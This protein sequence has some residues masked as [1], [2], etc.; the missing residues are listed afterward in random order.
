MKIFNTTY[1]I[2]SNINKKIVLISDL[3]Y[4]NKKNIFILN[5][6]FDKIKIINPDYVCITGDIIDHSTV[7]DLDL[8]INWLIKLSSKYKTVVVIGNHEYYVNKKEKIFNLD[9]SF[10]EKLS[11]INNLYFLNNKNIIIDN[12][13]FIGLDLGKEYYINKTINININNLIKKGYYNILLCHSPI[14]IDK[15]IN[16]NINLVLCGHMHGGLI[17]KCFRKIIKKA[18]IIDPNKKLFPKYVY[19]L[20]RINKIS[21]ITT[22]GITVLSHFNLLRLFNFIYSSEIVIIN[23]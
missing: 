7:F 22:S 13:N 12:I 14:N 15:I 9:N 4:F 17:P 20:K 21:I 18:G 3:H 11:N 6:V 8:L 1:N 5:K 2:E 23:L 19:G 16:D 10:I